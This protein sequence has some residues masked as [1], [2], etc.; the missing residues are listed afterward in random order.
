MKG[1]FWLLA[2]FAA[3]IALALSGRYDAG[4]V[5]FVIPP[6]RV[7][8][9]LLL[10][11]GGLLLAFLL[12]YAGL[13][14][15]QRVLA[16]PVSVRGYRDRRRRDRAN[17]TLA[18]AM[19]AL[20]EGRHARA[21]KEAAR[22]HEA[23]AAPGVAALIAARATHQLRDFEQ[24]DRWLNEAGTVGEAMSVA[25]S[26]TR[27]ELALEERDFGAARDALRALHDAGPKHIAT[28][29]MLLRAERGT[30]N[31]EEV[32]RLAALLA[33][34]DALAPAAA[35]EYRVQAQVALLERDAVDRKGFEKR[36]RSMASREQ[37]H[38]RVAETAARLAASLGLVALARE[39][40]ERGLT[41]EWNAT[42]AA[43]YGD[44]PGLEPVARVAEARA[45][46]E[47]AEK[48]LRD[49]PEDGTL[50]GALGR[51]CAHAEL[52]G[53]A[54]SYFEASL[55]YE[56]SAAAH[57]ELAR[58]AERLD[59]QDDAQRHFRRAAELH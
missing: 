50:L 6:W 5:L 3:A 17:R 12:L 44:L 40:L 26:V 55:A 30:G 14:L 2:A 47:R 25:R 59:R 19:Q 45:R 21:A 1:L 4:Y 16:I 56:E 48:W 57:L 24:R 43:Q 46:I 32:A 35:E 28:L 27:A 54:Q 51:L 23:G 49:R 33:K 9:S 11:L 31:W 52:W 13:R 41:A 10:F 42:L 38:P 53:K 58:L 8:V 22:A 39:I 20:F 15:A 29:R 7:E 37:A 18:D 34:R 36:W